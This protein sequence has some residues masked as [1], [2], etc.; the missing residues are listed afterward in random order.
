MTAL[1]ALLCCVVAQAAP[2]R[3]LPP[4]PA[5]RVTVF[6]GPVPGKN[7]FV[8]PYAGSRVFRDT[9]DDMRAV[10]AEEP[11]LQTILRLVSRPEEADLIVE[12]TAR[13]TD[14]NTAAKTIAA[15]LSVVG[16]DFTAQ[17]D[18]RQRLGVVATWHA[19]AKSLLRQTAD[20]ITANRTALDRVRASRAARSQAP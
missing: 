10:Y 7:G 2:D 18:S 9:Y 19:H 12:V 4:H 14:P 13:I 3:G 5:D 17:L 16:S 6:L 1:A 20:W 8:H 11:S 15:T